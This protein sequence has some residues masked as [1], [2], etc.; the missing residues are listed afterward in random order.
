M[1]TCVHV[2]LT[3]GLGIVLASATGLWFLTCRLSYDDNIQDLYLPTL[4]PSK[5]GIDLDIGD[6]ED[7]FNVIQP[8]SEASPSSIPSSTQ[9]CAP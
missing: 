3:I 9:T 1:L 7:W 6:R 4:T 5:I 2:V 8:L